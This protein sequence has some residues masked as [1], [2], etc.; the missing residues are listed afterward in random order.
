MPRGIPNRPAVTAESGVSLAPTKSTRADEVRQERRRKPGQVAHSGIKLSVDERVL[1]RDTYH[2]RYA[3]DTGA[4]V[5]QLIADD[6]DI[7]PEIGAKPDG[8]SL[9]SVNTTLAGTDDNGKPYNHVLMRKRKDWFEADQKE[10]QK[11][12]DAMDEAIRRGNVS[13]QN[14]ELKGP[15]VY[16]PGVNI[17]DRA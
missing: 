3:A 17:I 14:T 15:G 6:Y 8:N 11:P 9:G 10:K 7:A 13:A 4:R 12:L 16:T 2:Y 1:D 5:Q